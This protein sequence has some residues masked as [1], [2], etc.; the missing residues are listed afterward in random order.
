M[1][2]HKGKIIPKYTTD[3]DVVYVYVHTGIYM[4]IHM[5]LCLYMYELMSMYICQAI[6]LIVCAFATIWLWMC[7]D[8]PMQWYVSC[9]RV[10]FMC[11]WMQVYVGML[12]C[13]PISIN[14]TKYIYVGVCIMLI[15]CKLHHR[16]P[17]MHTD[18]LI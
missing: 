17:T 10:Y 15:P 11:L 8:L 4:H 2:I 3:T 7:S 16:C 12:G 5:F 13:M 14:Y 1:Y 6:F 9:M 18:N